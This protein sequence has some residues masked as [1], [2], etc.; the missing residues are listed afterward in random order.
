MLTIRQGWLI[1]GSRC[2]IDAERSPSLIAI[3]DKNEGVVDFY[4]PAREG[5]V[6]STTTAATTEDERP[7][8]LTSL[9]LCVFNGG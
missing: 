5:V 6:A 8:W 1:D 3:C 7:M 9:L 2:C 4:S